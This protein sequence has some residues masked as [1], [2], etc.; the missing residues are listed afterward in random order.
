[1]II[2]LLRPNRRVQITETVGAG[3]GPGLRPGSFPGGNV[4]WWL[5]PGR[6]A[7]A[8]AA[9]S[10]VA[11][12]HPA[13]YRVQYSPSHVLDGFLK[14]RPSAVVTFAHGESESFQRSRDSVRI[15]WF[16]QHQQ[17]RVLDD[18]FLNGIGSVTGRQQNRQI[19]P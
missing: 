7:A 1:M 17:A 3:K 15:V 16:G 5:A 2:L 19:G 14:D 18:P 12:N 11:T 4:R 10:L 9:M 6:R 13:D 8:T